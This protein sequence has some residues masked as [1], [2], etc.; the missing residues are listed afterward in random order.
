MESVDWNCVP[1]NLH[2]VPPKSLST[3]RA[4]IEILICFCSALLHRVAL[5]MESVDWNVKAWVIFTLIVSR[6][7]HGERGL[8]LSLEVKHHLSGQSL[9]TWRAWIEI[10]SLSFALY[11]LYCRSL[12]GERGLKSIY[13]RIP[14]ALLRRS[15]HGERGLKSPYTA[16]SLIKSSSLSTWR[17][18]IEIIQMYVLLKLNV[19]RSLH[20]ERGLK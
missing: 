10:P 8:K 7:L 18:W 17:A 19:G 1:P 13:Q 4:W 11:S 16:M 5:Y 12:H 15:L 20:G 3:W 6:S 2:L 14:S 9:S